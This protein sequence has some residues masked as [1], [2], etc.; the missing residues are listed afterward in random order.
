MRFLLVA[1]L[2]LGSVA[3]GGAAAQNPRLVQPSKAQ[4]AEAQKWAK[5]S[6]A[7]FVVPEVRDALHE[8]RLPKKGAD[9]A[10]K[11]M[12]RFAFSFE[13][14]APKGDLTDEGLKHLKGLDR[15]R[16]LDIKN[17]AVTGEGL[18]HLKDIADLGYLDLAHTKVGDGGAKILTT[19]FKRLYYLDLE[20]TE[21]TDAGV[22]ELSK[23]KKLAFLDVRGTKLTAEGLKK[24]QQAVDVAQGDQ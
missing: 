13:L 5:A 20:G 24:L 18:K 19:G 17:T 23:L 11:T 12:P 16:T 1:L 8:V 14:K 2:G 7:T 6:G 3:A 9:E 22:P 4:V 21:V 15:L 10:L